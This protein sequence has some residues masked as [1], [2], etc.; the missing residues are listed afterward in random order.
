MFPPEVAREVCEWLIHGR[1]PDDPPGIGLKTAIMLAGT[2]KWLYEPCV[3]ALWRTLPNV[4]L[5][6]WT[7][8]RE[9]YKR[10]RVKDHLQWTMFR[11]DPSTP[12]QKLDF[13]RFRFHAARVRV[14]KRGITCAWLPPRVRRYVLH[15]SALRDLEAH[16]ET[17]GWTILPNLRKLEF[18]PLPMPYTILRSLPSL[19]NPRLHTFHV[20]TY[21]SFEG[22]SEC[23]RPAEHQDFE[24]HAIVML[25][26]LLKICP[27]LREFSLGVIPSSVPIVK[28]VVDACCSF[29]RLTSFCCGEMTLPLTFKAITHLALLPDLQVLMFASDRSFWTFDDFWLLD[30]KPKDKIFP[31]LRNLGMI[32]STI[33]VP[34]KLLP[35]VSSRHLEQI[36][37]KIDG[38][39]SRKRVKPLFSAIADLKGRKAIEHIHIVMDVLPT[40]KNSTVTTDGDACPEPISETTLGPL[41]GL[42]KLSRLILDILCPWSINDDL[43][44]RMSLVWP[45]LTVLE[46][47]IERPW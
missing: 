9:C 2:S 46:L 5:L 36:T 33:D 34:L 24:E 39:V 4:A 30:H 16:F 17:A 45:N 21:D 47:G 18:Y 1:L 29:R 43:L 6:L 20:K 23:P 26:R 42:Y 41:L 35:Y 37:I 27:E 40:N 10:A 22:I 25:S 7:L 32:S 31:S 38:G 3:S 13:T 28:S 11:F 8:P 44:H 14:L 19:C 12:L 15:P